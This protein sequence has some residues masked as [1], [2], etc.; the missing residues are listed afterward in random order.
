[1]KAK[2]VLF[3]LGLLIIESVALPVSGAAPVPKEK[4][5]ITCE[6]TITGKIGELTIPDGGEV[7]ITNTSNETIDIGTTIGPLGFMDI[8]V[9]DAKG[10]VVKTEPYASFRSPSF[11]ATP[12]LL[13][14]GESFRAPLGLLFA[15]PEEKRVVGTYKV[16]CVFTFENKVY[17]SAEVEVKWPGAEK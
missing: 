9:R 13:K 11:K 6:L 4:P 8:K 16:K 15:V 2:Y 17:E 12:H 3:M 1:M 7:T 5:V 14:T 10:K